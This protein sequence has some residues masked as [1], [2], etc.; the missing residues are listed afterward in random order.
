MTKKNQTTLGKS[1]AVH[2]L[3]KLLLIWAKKQ[4]RCLEKEYKDL[5]FVKNTTQ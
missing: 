2:T 5:V 4:K 3:I 1:V